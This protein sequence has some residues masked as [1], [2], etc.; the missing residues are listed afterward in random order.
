MNVIVYGKD[1]QRDDVTILEEFDTV[2]EAIR[3]A[4]GYCSDQDMGN[5]DLVYVKDKNDIVVW[6]CY[7]EPMDWSDNAHEEF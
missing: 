2:Q 4:K 7:Q 1:I 6:S 5:W 3:W